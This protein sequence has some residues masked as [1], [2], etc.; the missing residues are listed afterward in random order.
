MIFYISDLGSGIKEVAV[1][2][3]T[4]V[5][6]TAILDW[7]PIYMTHSIVNV[8]VTIPDGGTGWVKLRAI[9]NGKL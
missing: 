9:N 8:S 7:S 4:T 5:D 2:V 3:G 1:S 6:N